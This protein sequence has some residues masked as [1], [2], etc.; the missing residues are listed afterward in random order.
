M[1]GVLMLFG[2]LGEFTKSPVEHANVDAASAIAK[3]EFS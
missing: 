2:M 3:I 1:S